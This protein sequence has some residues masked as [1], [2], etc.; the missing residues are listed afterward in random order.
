MLYQA[1]GDLDE[2]LGSWLQPGPAQA[3][4][5]IWGVNH[6]WKFSL[7][8]NT[9]VFKKKNADRVSIAASISEKAG[10]LYVLDDIS[11]KYL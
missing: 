9:N 4:T 1:H 2:V 6:G 10:K 8:L 5:V 3:L 7:S 11:W